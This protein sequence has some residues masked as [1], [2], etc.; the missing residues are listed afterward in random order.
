MSKTHLNTAPSRVPLHGTQKTAP[1]IAPSDVKKEGITNDN[2]LTS[3]NDPYKSLLSG[4][5]SATIGANTS[6]GLGDMLLEIK[7]AEGGPTVHEDPVQAAIKEAMMGAASNSSRIKEPWMPRVPDFVK[8][9][10]DIKIEKG[11]LKYISAQYSKR[12]RDLLGLRRQVEKF[13][14]PK[15]SWQMSP[16]EVSALIKQ[17][18]Y[19][20]RAISKCRSE[21]EYLKKRIE[22]A[23][24]QSDIN[25]TE[26]E[27]KKRAAERAENS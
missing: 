25:L 13:L 5:K 26:K 14:G 2:Y 4:G 18:K 7:E 16:E 22:L 3:G 15:Y 11:D 23:K 27:E 8:D 20:D 19:I 24:T 1:K 9:F 12:E 6:L 10:G 17:E 21:Q